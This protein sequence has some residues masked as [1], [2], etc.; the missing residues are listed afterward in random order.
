MP[1]IPPTPNPTLKQLPA[2][3]RP[4]ERL[5]RGG[6]AGL[7]DAELLAVLL[8]TGRPGQTAVAMAREI[9]G[10]HGGLDGLVEADLAS[11]RRRGLG[12]AKA[13]SIL[14]AVELGRRMVRCGLPKN[15]LAGPEAVAQYLRVRYSARH[16]EVMGALFLDIRN[17]LVGEREIYRGTLSRAA[18]EPRG[19][20]SEAL[21]HGASGL[22]LFHNHPS[23]DPA[24]SLEDL[25][26]TRRMRAAGELLGI[27]LVDHMIVG[28]AG[29]WVS[30]QRRG[31][32]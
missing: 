3:D 19:I 24:P 29:S 4:R 12:E 31:A 15:L 5:L 11:L 25:S 17:R 28:N 9:L 20:L 8:R 23:G 2:E 22:I 18:V 32:W 7:S 30:L 1:P 16:Q 13:A 21:K 10:Q 26:F 27:R 6:S 14:V